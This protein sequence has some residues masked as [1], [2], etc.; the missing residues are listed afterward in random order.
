LPVSVSDP[1]AFQYLFASLGFKLKMGTQGYTI[2]QT[3]TQRFSLIPF[4][5]VS[6]SPNFSWLS[7]G[8][9]L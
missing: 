1:S 3:Y 2:A 9:P 4:S 8:Q 5:P 6:T 7:Q